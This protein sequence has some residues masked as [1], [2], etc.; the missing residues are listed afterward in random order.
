MRKIASFFC[1][2]LFTLFLT[3]CSLFG[4]TST[5]SAITTTNTT[6]QTTTFDSANTSVIISDSELTIRL[7]SI[8]NLALDAGTI[9]GTYEEWLE[10]VKGPQGDPGRNVNLQIADG[11]IQWQYAGD[12]TWNNLIQLS[13]LVG[14]AGADGT[15]GADGEEIVFQVSE[16]Y[17]QWQYVGESTWINLIELTTLVGLPGAAG[18]NGTNGTDGKEVLFQVTDGYIQWQ[19]IGDLTWNNLIQ[20]STLVGPAGADG[21][22]VVFQVA[23]GY[24]QWRYVGDSVWS[25]L[26]ELTTLNGPAGESV[27]DIYINYH[28]DYEGNEE[29]WL[30]DLVNGRL[31]EKHIVTFDSHGGTTIIS[32]SVLNGDKAS[33]PSNPIKDG[34]N[35]FGWYYQDEL[36]VFIGYLVTSEM[37]LDAVY[38]PLIFE[39]T[40]Q[41]DGGT[42]EEITPTTSFS[43]ES[44]TFN[45]PEPTKE[46][47]VFAGWTYAGQDVPVHNVTI[48]HGSTG[49]IEFT[50]H[51]IDLA[52]LSFDAT[53]TDEPTGT[54]INTIYF[55]TI[56]EDDTF[57]LVTGS[58]FDDG[59]ITF[60][61]DYGIIVYLEVNILKL[62]FPNEESTD[63][64]VLVNG[65]SMIFCNEDGNPIEI[66]SPQQEGAYTI[67]DF[68]SE[69]LE[70]GYGYYDL[71]F[72]SNA[73]DLHSFYD[74]LLSNCQTFSELTIDYESGD[75]SNLLNAYSMSEYG[76][77]LNEGLMVFKVFILD[78][79]EF[80]WLSNT[81]NILG[82]SLN[83]YITPEYQSYQSRLAVYDGL[84]VMINELDEAITFEMSDLDIAYYLH[85]YI[86]SRID[87]AYE[88]DGITPQDDY[89]AHNIEGIVL[90]E[91]VVCEGYAEMYKILLDHFGIYNILLTGESGGQ[92][93]EFNLVNIEGTF[94]VIDLTWDDHGNDEISIT[95]FGMGYPSIIQTHTFDTP[96][97]IGINYL[98]HIPVLSDDDITLVNLFYNDNNLGWYVSIDSAFEDMTDSNG[99][100]EL[101]LVEYESVGP[102]LISSSVRQYI[103]PSGEWPSVQCIT[104]EG[105]HIPLDL[106]YFQ[107][108]SVSVISDIH[109]YSD[110]IIRDLVITR[111][112]ESEYTMFLGDKAIF[113]EGYY[114]QIWV[115]IEGELSSSL[116]NNAEYLSDLHGN[117]LIDNLN[118]FS[119]LLFWGDYYEIDKVNNLSNDGEVIV[120]SGAF[121]SINTL[122]AWI[123]EQYKTAIQIH[124]DSGKATITIDDINC[125]S[126]SE[127]NF[128][129]IFIH[130]DTLDYVP[131][132]YI[133]GN[134]NCIL[135]YQFFDY[136]VYMWTTSDGVEVARQVFYVNLYEY[137]ATP[138]INA[139]NLDFSNFH[140]Y[141]AQ[142]IELNGLYTKDV[143][144]DIYRSSEYYEIIEN[145]TLISVVSI[146]DSF[147]NTYVVPE[148][149]T[150]IGSGAFDSY[151]YLTH[152]ILSNSVTE[153]QNGAFSN[154]Y[155][156]TVYI[157]SS[158][159]V[160]RENAFNQMHMTLLLE[161][162]EAQP[163]WETGWNSS[164]WMS[165][166]WGY[167]ETRIN[168]E[169]IYAITCADEVAIL[170][171]AN[172]YTT[173]DVV[174][175]SEI[176][177]FLVTQFVS[178]AFRENSQIMSVFIPSTISQI[179]NL[180]FYLCVNLKNITFES[181]N[182][183]VSIGG[184][185]F[186]NCYKIEE[187][188]VPSSVTFAG[189][190]AFGNCYEVT[191]YIDSINQTSTW[192]ISWNLA[193]NGFTPV[194]V[195]N[196]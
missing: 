134:V 161:N 10:T 128:V 142:G 170:G 65:N 69:D 6:T 166:V 37:T 171:L 146:S 115:N 106:G 95:Y 48:S 41:L 12:E 61:A 2:T 122:N 116:S 160:I 64:F 157:P 139:P 151:M 28:P 23:D 111:Y 44:D 174:I 147:E 18:I 176:D 195:Y 133:T 7:R 97:E 58:I 180:A 129:T 145:D 49:S 63:L 71:S 100:Y 17:I 19:Y 35:F 104:I 191:V 187:I 132:I 173:V 84:M 108:T 34:Y 137:G 11:Y 168:G 150:S 31:G 51:W 25:N 32:Q 90:V 16:G 91:G 152:V 141:Y 46:G 114:S 138:I 77:T 120:H 165:V 47:Y 80:F 169:F 68:T 112:I 167:I 98:Y 59:T 78:H 42:F 154:F 40:Y 75:G 92:E 131:Y 124:S 143:N 182:S 103:L 181:R 186:M 94:Y 135:S 125:G 130:I 107:S 193:I 85:D 74:D 39:I 117:L 121:V 163:G 79:P 62:D 22:E 185:A 26:I 178:N 56:Y 13:T 27:Y 52:N 14:P 20:L 29:Q 33:K 81:L 184:S 54:I 148:G 50:A 72:Y 149:V 36:W 89:W 105:N 9:D 43:I 126:T 155:I 123:S 30:D 109:V 158:V 162:T 21:K 3:G 177:G 55:L 113:I 175:P 118:L 82:D 15:N 66:S 24:I 57:L 190:Q 5:T 60:V 70:I 159:T 196:D 136:F 1:F 53:V 88:E 87:Y 38:E 140:I 96:D 99:E 144:G 153:I 76:L 67:G 192:D 179:P 110:I 156:R 45:I 194:I 101:R 83:V 183:L 164:Y 8:Y 172:V 127:P 4:T 188:I 102:L 86:I 119:P 93:H 189:D 73:D